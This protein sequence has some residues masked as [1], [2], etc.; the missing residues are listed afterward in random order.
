VILSYRSKPLTIATDGMSVPL[1]SFQ[2][3]RKVS[4]TLRE[5]DENVK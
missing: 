3:A 1:E 5:K 2:P 4:A